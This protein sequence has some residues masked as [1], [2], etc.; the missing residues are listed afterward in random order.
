MTAVLPPG[1]PTLA[2]ARARRQVSEY[3]RP[4]LGA[5]AVRAVGLDPATAECAGC[6]FLLVDHHGPLVEG[7]GPWR[8]FWY[9]SEDCCGGPGAPGSVEALLDAYGTAD[10]VVLRDKFALPEEIAAAEWHAC[11]GQVAA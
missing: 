9:G 2:E 1:L 4:P 10:P 3:D 8:G 11:G 7:E 6:G 5:D